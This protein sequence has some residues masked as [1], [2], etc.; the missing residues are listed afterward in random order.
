VARAYT[1]EELSR[2]TARRQFPKLRGRGTE[3]VADLFQRVGPI[4]S[5]VAR[6]P[7]VTVSSRL[8]GATHAAVSEAYESL[9]IV[10][11]SSLRGTVHTSVRDQHR[12][13]DAVTR[14]STEKGWRRN[15]K[16]QRTTV[17]DIQAGI[18]DFAR[19]EWRTPEQ[20]REHL[21]GWLREH[22]GPAAADAAATTGVGRAFAHLHSGLVR[23]PLDGRPWDRQ[24]AP[25]YRTASVVLGDEPRER[26]DSVT[27]LVDLTRQHLRAFGPA[28]RR[29]IAWWTGEGLTAVDAAIAALVGEL[30]S[31]PG[32][33]G[34]TY[35]DLADAPTGGHADPG[36]RLLPEY[37]AVVVGYDPKSRDRFLDPA[38][39]PRIWMSA[40]G[41]FS[42]GVLSGGRLVAAWKL[43]ADRSRRRIDVEMFPGVPRLTE[44][45]LADQVAALE[46]ALAIEVDDVAIR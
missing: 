27:A 25:G 39:L 13:L 44:D 26:L 35:H 38:H 46:A 40:N 42:P 16:L 33:D 28:T 10:R 32:P 17:A 11:G 31:R 2:A 21:V 4:Q 3:A 7:F 23:K 1:W 8:P 5:Q 19:D 41:L 29:D 14:R 20:L 30:T 15:L 43:A 24:S 34:Q 36:V 37:D 12:L 6:S 45:D 9:R 18:E 22:E